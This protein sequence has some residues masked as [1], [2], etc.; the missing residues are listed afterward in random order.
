MGE[1]Q[2]QPGVQKYPNQRTLVFTLRTSLLRSL[3]ENGW[4]RD[5]GGH[6]TLL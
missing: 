2:G 5:R 4:T 1:G 3:R 6:L